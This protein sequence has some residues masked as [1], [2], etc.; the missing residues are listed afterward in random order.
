M[1]IMLRDRKLEI[2]DN[3]WII[4]KIIN[5]NLIYPSN[6]YVNMKLFDYTSKVSN[7]LKSLI[8]KIL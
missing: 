6:Q 3:S 5:F 1:E 7:P 2:I 4:L 8:T